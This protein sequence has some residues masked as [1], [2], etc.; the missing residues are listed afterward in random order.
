MPPSAPS[1]R[2]STVAVSPARITHGESTSARTMRN[3]RLG[4]MNKSVSGFILAILF[5]APASSMTNISPFLPLGSL[6]CDLNSVACSRSSP[7]SRFQLRRSWQQKRPSSL[8]WSIGRDVG[9]L[10][11]FLGGGTQHRRFSFVDSQVRGI[12]EARQ[13]RQRS[14]PKD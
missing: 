10:Y 4:T 6:S 7:A 1:T 3:T 14:S 13:F 9:L 5:A 11:G 2:P 8:L 12:L